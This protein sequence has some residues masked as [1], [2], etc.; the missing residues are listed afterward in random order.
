MF[1]ECDMYDMSTQKR[2]RVDADVVDRVNDLVERITGR[3]ADDIGN[4]GRRIEFL[5]AYGQFDR[6]RRSN[7]RNGTKSRDGVAGTGR[8]NGKS[9]VEMARKMEERKRTNIKKFLRE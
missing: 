9:A 4:F 1:V 2:P 3:E 7:R 6:S 5:L 8:E